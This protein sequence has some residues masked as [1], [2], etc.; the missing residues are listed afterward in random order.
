MTPYERFG[1]WMLHRFDAETAH[2]LSLMA[3][4]AG[5]APM[6]GLHTSPALET[7]LAGMT[8]PNPVSAALHLRFGF[9]PIGTFREVGQKFDR[10]WDVEWY[11]KSM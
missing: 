2:R 4:K 7:T 5:V 1:M 3:L 9:T 11:E 6:P 8:L 10:Y